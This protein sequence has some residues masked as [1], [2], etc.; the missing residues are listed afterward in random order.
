M[1]STERYTF[2]LYKFK[3]YIEAEIFPYFF[4]FSEKSNIT[5]RRRYWSIL[6]GISHSLVYRFVP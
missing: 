3:A 6:N 4:R 2:L 1:E 5:F